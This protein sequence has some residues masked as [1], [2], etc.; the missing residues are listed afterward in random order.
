MCWLESIGLGHL[1]CDHPKDHVQGTEASIFHVHSHPV[2]ELRRTEAEHERTRLEH[3][4]HSIPGLAGRNV[5]IPAHASD[6]QAIGRIS[7]AGIKGVGLHG[8]H[9]CDVVVTDDGM[10]CHDV[11]AF[12]TNTLKHG[13]EPPWQMFFQVTLHLSTVLPLAFLKCIVLPLL[14][15]FVT[16]W[17]MVA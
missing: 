11:N 3:A 17:S 16:L 14:I 9:G 15:T 2:I 13:V 4:I 12:P 5:M 10:F 6:V 7:D 8:I 1:G